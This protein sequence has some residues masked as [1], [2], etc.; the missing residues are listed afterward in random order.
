[1]LSQSKK[2]KK[3]RH[4]STSRSEN[5]LEEGELSASSGSER[6][7]E[8]DDMLQ[9]ERTDEENTATNEVLSANDSNFDVLV[10]QPRKKQRTL[11]DGTPYFLFNIYLTM[12]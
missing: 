9:I 7:K 10:A 2:K 4:R 1:M 3:K 12:K 11:S 8:S 6:E 5:S